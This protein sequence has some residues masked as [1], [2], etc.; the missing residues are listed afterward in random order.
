MLGT[1]RMLAGNQGLTSLIS[2]QSVVSR[3]FSAYQFP[4]F[5]E[6]KGTGQ[7]FTGRTRMVPAEA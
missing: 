3:L 1:L 6:H 5:P 2:Y 4:D 7:T